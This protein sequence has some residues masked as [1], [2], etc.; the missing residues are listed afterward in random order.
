ME[1]EESNIEPSEI[2]IKIKRLQL[3]QLFGQD[4]LIPA[5]QLGQA[6]VGDD[7]GAGP[8]SVRVVE[9]EWRERVARPICRAAIMRPWPAMMVAPCT[10]IGLAKP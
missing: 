6:V 5:G 8:A 9:G 3:A 10:R 4:G 2:N 7:V 1:L